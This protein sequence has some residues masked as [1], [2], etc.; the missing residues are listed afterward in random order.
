MTSV[1][2]MISRF[3]WVDMDAKKDAPFSS[4]NFLL[5]WQVKK[6]KLNFPDKRG[7]LL[8]EMYSFIG[9]SCPLKILNDLNLNSLFLRINNSI[10]IWSIYD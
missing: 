6:T 4:P 1:T 3:I 5:K 8:T 10:F 7:L 9:I 2:P